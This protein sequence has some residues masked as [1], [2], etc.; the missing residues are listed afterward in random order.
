MKKRLEEV[1][2]CS[3]L[4]ESAIEKSGRKLERL[5][6]R[7]LYHDREEVTGYAIVRPQ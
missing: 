4:I 5:E 2:Y 6:F 3:H 1:E 7:Q